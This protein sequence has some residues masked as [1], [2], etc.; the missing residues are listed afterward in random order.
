MLH[1]GNT[2]AHAA[3]PEAYHLWLRHSI[4]RL[5][6]QGLGSRKREGGFWDHA[7]RSRAFSLGFRDCFRVKGSG[8]RS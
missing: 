6:V 3:R 1:V 5:R 2:A 7:R 8:L 4:F